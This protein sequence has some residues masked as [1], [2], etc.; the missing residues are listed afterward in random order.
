MFHVGVTTMK[1]LDKCQ[2]HPKLEVPASTVGGEHSRKEPFEQLVNSY[3]EHLHMS[4]RQYSGNISSHVWG[5]GG[6]GV[7]HFGLGQGAAKNKDSGFADQCCIDLVKACG[8]LN[9][10]L[11]WPGHVAVLT[12]HLSL[13]SQPRAALLDNQIIVQ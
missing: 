1:K 11:S 12:Q 13:S 6:R 5:G 2:L 4:P 3:S 9:S 8:P 10:V 7:S